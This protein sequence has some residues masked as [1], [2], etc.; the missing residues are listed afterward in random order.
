MRRAYE[1]LLRLY[2]RD[3]RAMFAPEMSSAFEEASAERQCRGWGVYACF[4]LAELIGLIMGAGIEWLAKLT[5]DSSVRGRSL[6]DRLLMRPPG[7]SWDAHYAGAFPSVP[8]EVS[9]AQQRTELLV[10]RIVHA[11]SHHDFTGARRYSDEERQ[12]REHLRRLRQ[13]Y[14]ISD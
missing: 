12:A 3:Y 5:T 10:R 8:E 13:K 1:I 9:K 11:I 4:A 14:D 2:P 6:P 7:V